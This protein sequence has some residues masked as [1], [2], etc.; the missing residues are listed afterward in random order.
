MQFIRKVLCWIFACT[1]FLYLENFHQ[2]ILYM[3][4][5][6]YAPSVLRSLLIAASFD[7]LVAGISGVAWWTIWKG[8]TSARGW[9]VAASAI[10]ILIFLRQFIIRSRP[11]WGHHVGALIIGIVGLVTFMWRD[12]HL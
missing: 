11:V 1:S 9:A 3:I 6:D 12:K 10:H 5:Q 8:V 4:H 2:V 7:I